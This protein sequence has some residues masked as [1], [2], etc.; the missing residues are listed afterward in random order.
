MKPILDRS[1]K[2]LAYEND[3]NEYRKEIRSRSNGLL[4]WYNPHLDKT[5]DRSGRC[6]SNSG[7]VRASL[8]PPS[9]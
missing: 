1:G 8:I 7:D 4:G 3:V 5:F 6:V 2:V 9:K